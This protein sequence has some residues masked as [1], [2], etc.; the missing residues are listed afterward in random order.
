MLKIIY[1][2]DAIYRELDQ[3]ITISDMKICQPNALMKTNRN[4]HHIC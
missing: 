2:T 3:Q 4:L 1:Y